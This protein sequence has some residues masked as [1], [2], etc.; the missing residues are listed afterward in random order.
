VQLE[1]KFEECVQK[2]KNDNMGI[3]GDD[4]DT[5]ANKKQLIEENKSRQQVNMKR[6]TLREETRGLR[7]K[8]RFDDVR[9]AREVPE[10][11]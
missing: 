5:P 8:V 10:N 1:K 9:P 2:S 7:E 3:D 4:Y 11:L 6:T